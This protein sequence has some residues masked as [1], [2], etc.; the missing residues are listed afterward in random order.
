MRNR[1]KKLLPFVKLLLGHLV[2]RACTLIRRRRFFLVFV[3]NF[4][5]LMHL[6]SLLV[7]WYDI[8]LFLCCLLPYIYMQIEALTEENLRLNGKLENAL[9]K[10]DV[11]SYN[12]I[13]VGSIHL[14][15]YYGIRFCILYYNLLEKNCFSFTLSLLWLSLL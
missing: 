1:W 13:I 11:V 14:E 3:Y 10:L 12:V 15:S 8:H 5:F 9:G 2:T 6:L 7:F 4:N